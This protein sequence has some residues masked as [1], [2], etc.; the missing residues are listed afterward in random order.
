MDIYAITNDEKSKNKLNFG[1][2]TFSHIFPSFPF[3]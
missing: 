1:Y 3:F 2:D